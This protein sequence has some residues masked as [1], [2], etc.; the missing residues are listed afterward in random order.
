MVAMPAQ[1]QVQLR[2]AGGWALVAFDTILGLWSL[3]VLNDTSST[4]EFGGV[5]GLVALI[6]AVPPTIVL[7]LLMLAGGSKSAILAG[8]ACL[9][10]TAGCIAI[11]VSGPAPI[12]VIPIGAIFGFAGITS[13]AAVH[14]RD[15]SPQ[16][17][18][19]SAA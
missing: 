4:D 6:V 14:A 10:V 7:A 13:L 5:I 15:K 1:Q 17:Q 11:V 9:I 12:V 19:G 2:R 18:P 3:Y 8:V 16:V